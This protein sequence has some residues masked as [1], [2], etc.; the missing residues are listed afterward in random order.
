MNQNGVLPP[1]GGL[2]DQLHAA[3]SKRWSRR[4]RGVVVLSVLLVVTGLGG[5][6]YFYWLASAIRDNTSMLPLPR[7]VNNAPFITTPADVVEKMIELAS[8]TEDDLLY[9]LGC[10]D[11][12][13]AITAAKKYGCRAV[14]Y[15]IDPKR[16]EE[17]RQ[18]VIDNGMEDLVTIQQAD[19]FALDLSPA[20]RITMYLLPG[21]IAKLIPQLEQLQP[22]S[23]IVSHDF[24]MEGVPPDEVVYID[25]EDGKEHTLYV[26]T[27][28][29]KRE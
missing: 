23:R 11:G 1:S 4:H 5:T 10:G 28:P 16:V 12:R 24:Q 17:S 25:S 7:P 27:T 9:D 3:A 20:T 8:I 22:G 14:G 2:P 29:L 15:D 13:I 26:W 18:S 21:M 19:V 6:V